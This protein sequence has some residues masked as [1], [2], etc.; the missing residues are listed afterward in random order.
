[1]SLRS[2]Y[3]RRI[4]APEQGVEGLLINEAFINYHINLILSLLKIY[5]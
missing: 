2:D 5:F 4:C 3:S 1:M